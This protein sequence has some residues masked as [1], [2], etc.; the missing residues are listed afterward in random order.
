MNLDSL[1]QAVYTRLNNVTAITDAVTGIY[2]KAPQPDAPEDD[3]AF[4]YITIGPIISTPQDTKDDN[5]IMALV[6][7]HIWSRSQSALS[8]RG[9]AGDVYDALQKYALTVT[10]ANVIDCRFDSET[11]FQ[12]PE[13]GRTWHLVMTWRINYYLT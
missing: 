1:Q 4:P 8:W 7:V 10:G 5:G 2:T 13:D 3:A 11:D 9:I 12:D 6:D